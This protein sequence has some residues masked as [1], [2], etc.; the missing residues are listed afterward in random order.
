MASG[1]WIGL[2]ALYVSF[3]ALVLSH[4]RRPPSVASVRQEELREAMMQLQ[5]ELQNLGARTAYLEAQ[6]E[7]LRRVMHWR[8]EEHNSTAAEP[9]RQ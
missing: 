2:V 8:Q 5:T 7:A 1:Q 3:L 4:L 9:P 6:T